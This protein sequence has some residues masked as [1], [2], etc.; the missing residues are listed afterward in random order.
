LVPKRH[1][2]VVITSYSD[3]TVEGRHV[4]CRRV[5]MCCWHWLWYKT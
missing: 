3:F 1:T 2:T 5:Y 4:A